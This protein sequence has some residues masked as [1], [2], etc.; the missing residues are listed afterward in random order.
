[1]RSDFS[2]NARKYF[3]K[4]KRLNI[5]ASITTEVVNIWRE[6]SHFLISAATVAVRLL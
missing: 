4:T 1:M 5:Y 6:V 2:I 3:F